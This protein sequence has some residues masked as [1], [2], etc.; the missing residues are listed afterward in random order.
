MLCCETNLPRVSGRGK[1]Q[2][3]RKDSLYFEHFLKK[4]IYRRINIIRCLLQSGI[5]FFTKSK[6][7]RFMWIISLTAV[8]ITVGLSVKTEYQIHKSSLHSRWRFFCMGKT[9]RWTRGSGNV[10]RLNKKAPSGHGGY[11]A[12]RRIEVGGC[13][14]SSN[15]KNCNCSRGRKELF[16]ILKL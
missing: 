12:H 10:T 16:D 8:K 4:R 14:Y 5:L 6:M 15:A 2:R 3:Y 13:F 7:I 11:L 9:T 1:L